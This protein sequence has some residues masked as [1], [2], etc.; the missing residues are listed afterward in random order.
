MKIAT[1]LDKK[2]RMVVTVKPNATILE[3]A[4]LLRRQHI[5]C[6]VVSRDDK[7]IEGLLAVPDVVY[8]LAEREER[9][10]AASGTDILDLPIERIMT[11]EVH[12]CTENDTLKH[13]MLYM[14][15]RH[16]PP[17]SGG[18]RWRTLRYRQQR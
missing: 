13:V 16:Y 10:R 18:G 4:E 2:G 3:V 6:M 7:H 11:H 5:G 17:C 1:L 8:A 12:T 14:A 9:I 15:R